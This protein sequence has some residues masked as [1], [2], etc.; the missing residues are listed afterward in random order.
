MFEEKKKI[1]PKLAEYDRKFREYKLQKMAVQKAKSLK[2]DTNIDKQMLDEYEKEEAEE[3]QLKEIEDKYD[4]GRV[5][6]TKNDKFICRFIFKQLDKE[7]RSVVSKEELYDF[8]LA[9]EL[10]MANF[11]ID[12]RWFYSDLQMLETKRKGLLNVD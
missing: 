9:N 12:K 4:T 10:L 1:D 7:K 8:L 6:A 11:K 3:V 2:K 5:L